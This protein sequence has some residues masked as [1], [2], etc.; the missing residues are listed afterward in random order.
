MFDE[1]LRVPLIITGPGIAPQTIE[2]TV[3]TI[4]LLPTL[5]EWTGATA[6]PE[7]RGKS[8]ANAL[9]QDRFEWPDDPI[10]SQSTGRLPPPPEPLQAVSVGD[11]KL[12][13]G[14]E[15]GQLS[16]FDRSKDPGEKTNL[17]RSHPHIVQQLR[18]DLE[19]WSKSFPVTFDGFGE[20]G[21]MPE[22]DREMLENLKALGYLPDDPP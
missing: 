22:P 19:R 16:L 2:Q 13:L 10:Y 7:W 17:A 3:S 5:A 1:L 6:D 11:Y 9:E 18:G 8:W 12:I 21:E 15:S 20:D 14:L 4:D